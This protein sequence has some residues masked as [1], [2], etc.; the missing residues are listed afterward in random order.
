MRMHDWHGKQNWTYALI[1]S[2]HQ[3]DA[4]NN[5]LTECARRG[6]IATIIKRVFF[7]AVDEKNGNGM[8]IKYP[9]CN[10]YR[11]PMLFGMDL[12]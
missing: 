1:S 5:N 7:R 10:T 11:Y 3:K 6:K 2:D 12:F 8:G 9:I 4:F